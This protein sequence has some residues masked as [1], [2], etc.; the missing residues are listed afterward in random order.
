MASATPIGNIAECYANALAIEHEDA[1]QS[2]IEGVEEAAALVRPL[3][4]E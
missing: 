3:L 4:A 2:P 1:A